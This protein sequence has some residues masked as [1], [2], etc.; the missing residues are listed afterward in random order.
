MKTILHFCTLFMALVFI[1]S[2]T[3][4]DDANNT[5]PSN[6]PTAL[7]VD[8][9]TVGFDNLTS[10]SVILKGNAI[11][12][13]PD[14]ADLSP[15]GF[16]WSETN[17]EPTNQDENVIAKMALGL[18]EY[19]EILEGLK[20][21]TQ[22]YYRAHVRITAV[23]DGSPKSESFYGEV[24]T[25]TTEKANIPSV[26][27]DDDVADITNTTAEISG[28]VLDDFDEPVT[29]RGIV[30]NKTGNPTTSDIIFNEGSGLG[31][32]TASVNSLEVGT[33][34]YAKAFATNSS[35]TAYGEEVSFTTKIYR[36]DEFG[37]GIVINGDD[38]Q[39]PYFG[40]VIAAPSDQSGPTGTVWG[41]KGQVISYNSSGECSDKSEK[42]A[43]DCNSSAA[44]LCENLS[45]GGYDDWFLPCSNHISMMFNAKSHLTGI[46]GKIYWYL[47]QLNVNEARTMNMND[48]SLKFFDKN[49]LHHVRAVRKL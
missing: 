6:N 1:N 31:V 29:D 17:P 33:T 49:D 34:Y 42:V 46:D 47:E 3:K 4:E 43:D 23:V 35:G 11:S 32:F 9:E 21:N 45:I 26:S 41:C 44:A 22:Y 19:Q 37:G 27:T 10:T 18:G 48:G 7:N 36:G 14:P 16:V 39:G 13:N 40:I 38:T 20:A 24:K 30:L 12:S 28:E 8:L 5:P 2:C 15:I 25:F